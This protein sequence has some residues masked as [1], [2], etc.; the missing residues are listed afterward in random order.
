[1]AP[2]STAT[3]GKYFQIK[4]LNCSIPVP[5]HDNRSVVMW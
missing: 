4:I 1:M 3:E 5:Y 2:P